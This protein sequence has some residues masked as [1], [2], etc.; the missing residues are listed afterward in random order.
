MSLTGDHLALRWADVDWER[1]RITINSPKTG[2]RIIPL[3]ADLRPY[4]EEQ[5]ELA[6][7][8]T[9]YVI[10][11]YRDCSVNLRTQLERIIQ[12]AGVAPWPKLFQNLRSTRET[13]LCETYP[14][15]VVCQWL[16]N[17]VPMAAKHYLQVTDSHFQQATQNPAQ[18]LHAQRRNRQQGSGQTLEIASDC[19]SLL[20]A[21]GSKVGPEG[22]EPP[23]KGFPV[24]VWH[25]QSLSDERATRSWPNHLAR[26]AFHVEIVQRD[27][28]RGTKET[29]P[30]NAFTCLNWNPD[31]LGDVVPCGRSVPRPEPTV[32]EITTVGVI[33]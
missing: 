15:H 14:V 4:V 26:L 29:Y 12:R 33:E 9:E 10:N 5:F 2:N 7:P 13:E 8:G 27:F 30:Q 6:E 16:G 11:R 17:S 21:A 1:E 32:T 19:D 28:A 23:T 31:F 25:A 20:S 3:F 18:C 22:S 24:T